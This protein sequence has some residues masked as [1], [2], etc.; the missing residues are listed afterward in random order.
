ML[1]GRAT[2]GLSGG[3]QWRWRL[4]RPVSTPPICHSHPAQTIPACPH[5]QP[6]CCIK[7]SL[8]HHKPYPHPKP[9]SGP[10]EQPLCRICYG[11]AV[12]PNDPLLQ[13]C[14]C[15]GTSAH[16]HAS[17]LASCEEVSRAPV[18]CTICCAHIRWRGVQ[19]RARRG[20][21]RTAAGW[22]L[23]GAVMVAAACAAAAGLEAA[24]QQRQR[25]LAAQGTATAGPVPGHCSGRGI[26][27]GGERGAGAAPHAAA[28]TSRAAAGSLYLHLKVILCKMSL[29]TESSQVSQGA[30]GG[31]L[32]QGWRRPA[33]PRFVAAMHH[34]PAPVVSDQPYILVQR[35]AWC[36]TSSCLLSPLRLGACCAPP[37]TSRWL[38]PSHRHSHTWW[39]Q[40]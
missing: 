33:A 29:A 39:K 40:P 2:P 27:G 4:R 8:H 30:G 19:R 26:A 7:P 28:L 24:K 21:L 3:E 12:D 9:H 31:A 15:R 17:C 1:A 36:S 23:S 35:Q 37:S 22:T 18:R 11:P 32:A 38:R 10:Q 34:S 25:V 16:I 5:E 20:P 14:R 6:L 13:P